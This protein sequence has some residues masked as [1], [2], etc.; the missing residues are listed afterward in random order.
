MRAP[1]YAQAVALAL[2]VT[3]LR[4]VAATGAVPFIYNKLCES[5]QTS[6]SFVSFNFGNL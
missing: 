2:T 4:Y 1:F 5:Q 3:G 6:K